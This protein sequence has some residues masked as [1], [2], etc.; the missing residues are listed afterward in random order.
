MLQVDLD[1]RSVV[2]NA[3]N[4]TLGNNLAKMQLQMQ[5]EPTYQHI[6]GRDSYINISMTVFGEKELTKL[7]KT[8]DFISG[9]ARLEHAAGVIGFLG[10]KNIVTAL[11][12]IKY[13]MPLSYNVDTIPN[14]PHVYSVQLS[15][16]DFDV[17]QQKREHISSEQQRKF[18]EDFKSKRN[19]FL[20]LKQNWS[21]F[22][23]YPDMPL[24]VKDE[25]GNVVG[26]L[27]PDFYFR[28]FE[29]FDND[30]INN[31]VDPNSYALPISSTLESD[32]LTEQQK[33]LA[34]EV[35]QRLIQN[36]GTLQSIKQYLIDQNNLKPEVAMKVFRYAIFDEENDTQLEKDNLNASGNLSN[37]YP[38][39]WKDF[40]EGMVDEL[41]EEHAFEDL[42]FD[43][44]YGQ[45]RIGDLVSG[46]KEQMDTFTALVASSEFN[47]KENKLPYFNPD[48]ANFFGIVQYIPAADSA[49]L[50]KIPAIY[51]TP[52]AGFILG[53][54]DENDGNFYIASDSLNMTQD[55]SG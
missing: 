21:V 45:V 48:D 1:P 33:A 55:S 40:I 49:A 28:S 41:G 14:F 27:D 2:V 25:G 54:V 44:K 9:L 18:I 11:C 42:K 39:L 29:M 12:G 52:D 10:I 8:F 38:T 26:C 47:L 15:L 46:S 17:Y 5:D 53:Y 20:R 13:A 4:V 35:K 6:G 30:V 7:K 36:N 24:Q 16:V 31:I 32:K 43:T 22:N 51:Q 19:P 50:N 3:V 34:N 23:G 37:K